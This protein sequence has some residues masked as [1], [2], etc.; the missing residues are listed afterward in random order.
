MV[1]VAEEGKSAESAC[2]ALT[3]GEEWDWRWAGTLRD[4]NPC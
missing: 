1:A 3:V 4:G 2:A